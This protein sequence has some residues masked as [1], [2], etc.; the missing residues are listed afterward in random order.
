[1]RAVERLEVSTMAP[2]VALR[3]RLPKRRMT[4]AMTGAPSRTIRVSRQSVHAM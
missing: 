4:Q 2:V 3:M 1:M